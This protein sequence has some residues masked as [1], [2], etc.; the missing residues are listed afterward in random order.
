[1]WPKVRLRCW[2][3]PFCAATMQRMVFCAL[4]MCHSVSE[5]PIGPFRCQYEIWAANPKHC[6]KEQNGGRYPAQ[7]VTEFRLGWRH[8]HANNRWHVWW[9]KCHSIFSIG[10]VKENMYVKYAIAILLA[11]NLYLRSN[12]LQYP[13]HPLLQ[14]LSHWRCHCCD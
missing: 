2:F 5:L 9:Q 4:E 1:M 10:S 12:F 11:R 8:S 13:F 6:G 14:C 7:G 3:L